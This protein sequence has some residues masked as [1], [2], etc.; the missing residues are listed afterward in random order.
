MAMMR[1][2]TFITLLLITAAIFIVAAFTLPRLVYGKRAAAARCPAALRQLEGATKTWALEQ[3]RDTNAV[4][5][6]A[7]LFGPALYLKVKPK[8]PDG[9]VYILGSASQP[10]RCSIAAHNRPR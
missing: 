4:P 5:T 8:C 2:N 1:G 6:D 9:G 3:G 7:D 10:P